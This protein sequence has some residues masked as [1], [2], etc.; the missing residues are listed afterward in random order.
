MNKESLKKILSEIVESK[1]VTYYCTTYEIACIKIL[2][3][4]AESLIEQNEKLESIDKT[5][6]VYLNHE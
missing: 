2:G 4:I 3:T 5:L 6:Q 1:E